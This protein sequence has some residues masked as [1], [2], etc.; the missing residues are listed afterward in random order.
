MQGK[1]KIKI[2]NACYNLNNY[3][4]SIQPSISF[5]PFFTLPVCLPVCPKDSTTAGQN[6]TSHP[7][8]PGTNMLPG[9]GT[10]PRLRWTRVGLGRTG[11]FDRWSRSIIIST[12]I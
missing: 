3:M 6:N 8:Y 7:S 4:P 9:T 11:M 5:T 10:A 1:R 12:N 2:N